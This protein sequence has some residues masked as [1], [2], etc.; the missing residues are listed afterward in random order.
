MTDRDRSG[1]P[2]ERHWDELDAERR[3]IDRALIRALPV[4]LD[5]AGFAI[6]PIARRLD[7]ASA[8][9]GSPTSASG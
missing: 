2:D 7:S 9:E 8:H 3:E 1:H 6:V 5:D 4:L